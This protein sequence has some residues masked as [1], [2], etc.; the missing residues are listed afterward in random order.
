MI[1]YWYRLVT[2]I[3]GNQD[4]GGQ[5]VAIT[6]DI[7]DVSQLLG[8][9]CKVQILPDVKDQLKRNMSSNI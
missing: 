1:R 5:G 9:M 2:N 4:I 8:A 7:I 6:D 3:G